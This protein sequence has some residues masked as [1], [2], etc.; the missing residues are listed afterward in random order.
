M[1]SGEVLTE[2]R[3]AG[4]GE[5]PGEPMSGLFAEVVTWAAAGMGVLSAGAASS[6]P[7]ATGEG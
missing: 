7:P 1:A 6:L 5:G 3:V 2:T 4:V